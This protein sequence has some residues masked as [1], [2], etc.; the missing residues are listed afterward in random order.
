[1]KGWKTWVSGLGSIALGVYEII[2]GQVEAGIG[3]IVFGGGLIGLGHKID[4]AAA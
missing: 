1:M 2:D 3:H 4:K